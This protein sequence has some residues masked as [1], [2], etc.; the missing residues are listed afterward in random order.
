[1]TS[2]RWCLMA[3]P[4]RTRWA[5]AWVAAFGALGGCAGP[6]KTADIKAAAPQQR[7]AAIH[8]A[9]QSGNTDAIPGLI[10]QLASDDPA[11]RMYAIQALERITGERRGFLPQDPPT[12]RAAAILRVQLAVSRP[13]ARWADRSP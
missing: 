2:L 13:F 1:M 9:G 3:R 4:R 5:L 8:D 11:V 7:I 12:K 6:D 10:E